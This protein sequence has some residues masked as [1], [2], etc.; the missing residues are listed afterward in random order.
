M[1][2]QG[3]GLR[4]SAS[5]SESRYESLPLSTHDASDMIY[6]RLPSRSRTQHAISRVVQSESSESLTQ[7]DDG[8]IVPFLLIQK[9]RDRIPRNA[10]PNAFRSWNVCVSSLESRVRRSPPNLSLVERIKLDRWSFELSIPVPAL[11]K[12]F[13][14][15]LDP[16]KEMDA[17]NNNN[18]KT[19]QTSPAS[20]TSQVPPKDEMPVPQEGG[21]GGTGVH[22]SC[23]IA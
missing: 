12:S 8:F 16:L 6:Q 15:P 13:P 7:Y 10:V 4:Y 17:F 18:V 1:Q 3:R 14:P 21:G 11:T 22:P 23:V 9:C 2:V 19:T 20:G 5:A